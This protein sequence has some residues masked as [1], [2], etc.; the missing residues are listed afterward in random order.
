[1]IA[2]KRL[3]NFMNKQQYYFNSLLTQGIKADAFFFPFITVLFSYSPLLPSSLT[4]SFLP[5]SSFFR[6]FFFLLLILLT[7]GLRVPV[8]PGL[9]CSPHCPDRIWGSPK[10]LYNG[11]QG[12]FL[13]QLMPKSRIRGFTHPLPHTSS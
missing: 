2:I 6:L 7:V 11:H 9:F 1:M 4:S 8:G 5:C 10:L 3:L 12:S 13:L